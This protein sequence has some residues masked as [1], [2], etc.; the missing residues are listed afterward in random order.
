MRF[1]KFLLFSFIF[2]SSLYARLNIVVSIQPEVSFVQAIAKDLVNI[3]LMVKPG[4]EPHSYEP[5]PSQMKD[6]SKADIYFSI[7]VE[8]EQVWLNKFQDINHKMLII[9]LSKHINKIS[10]V[11]QH[12]KGLDPHIWTS[13]DN[14]QIIAKDILDTLILKDKQHKKEYEKNYKKFIAKIK[15]TNQ[16]IKQILKDIP[17][18]STFMVFHPSFGYFAKQYHLKQLPIQIEGKNPKPRQIIKLIDLARVNHIKAIIVSPLFSSKIA[19]QISNEL[20][21]KVVKISAL[22]PNWSKNLI[23]LAKIIANK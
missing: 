7:G 15:S 12:H 6:I 13:L 10:M 16:Q 21:I 9:D 22:D 14:I 1:F 17:T 23:Y 8:F 5:K 3:S 18:N 11:E 2:T 20:N 4:H 19:K